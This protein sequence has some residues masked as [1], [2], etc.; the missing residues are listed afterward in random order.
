MTHDNLKVR[1]Y[2]STA[3][4]SGLSTE[5]SQLM[6]SDTSGQYLFTDTWIKRDGRWQCVA[7]HLSEV[8]ETTDDNEEA[9]KTHSVWQGTYDQ[10]DWKVYP[11]VLFISSR[12]GNAFEGMTWYPTLGNGLIT[13]SGEIK[14]DGVITFT[15]DE[16][17]YGEESVVS[18]CIYTGSLKGNTLK[19][20]ATLE[21]RKTG[22]FVLK[23][24]D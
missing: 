21:D 3:V 15:E 2:G 10:V 12:T 18:G 7:T 9:I 22:D 19:G 17:L 1:V 4:I 20:L 24:A 6:G 23:L 8:A 16:V 5:K 13:M 11:M 14:P